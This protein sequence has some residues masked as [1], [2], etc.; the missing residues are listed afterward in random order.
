MINKKILNK[1]IKHG[2]EPLKPVN[3]ETKY[4][5]GII[6]F[7]PNENAPDF[8]KGSVVIT[9]NDLIEYLKTIEEHA[10][11]YKGKTQ[12]RFDLLEG[13]KGLYLKHDTFKPKKDEEA[14]TE[15]NDDLPF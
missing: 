9:P 1:L 15:T 10:T 7:E 2:F 13:N 11:K 3:M 8:V 14:K 5:K 6:I 12:F 4:P